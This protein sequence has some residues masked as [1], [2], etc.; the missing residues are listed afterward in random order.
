MTKIEE[1]QAKLATL[2][3][4]AQDHLDKDDNDNA[5]KTMKE[6]KALKT[7][8]DNQIA[9]DELNKT[10]ETP[11][12]KGKG[13]PN[14]N[15]DDKQA[16]NSANFIR[17]CL[18]KIAKKPTT[19]KEDA[20]LL[21]TTALPNGANGEGYILPQDIQ[22]KIN[23][24]IRDFKSFRSVLGHIQ[25]TALTGSFPVENIDDIT[26]LVDFADGTD[27]GFSEDPKFTQIKFALAEKAAFIKLSN[28]LMRLTDND[29]IEY[30]VG[31]FAKKAVITENTMAIAALQN[32]KT[33]KNIADWKALKSSIN[34]DLDPAALYTTKIVTNQ[35]GYDMFDSALDDNG[36]PIMQPDPTNPTV[37]RLFGYEVLVFSNAMLPSTAATTSKPGYAPIFYGAL[38]DGAKFVDLGLTAFKTSEEAGFMSNTTI[39]RLIEF[40]D[41]VQCDSSDACYICG[42]I[43]VEP[44]KS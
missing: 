5:E 1:M 35:D 17:A 2:I 23:E 8:I 26:G 34:K 32:D 43:E 44:K 6:I 14:D 24:R 11:E 31:Y 40:I 38:S 7:K 9:L 13:K 30:I 18:K 33:V 29:L 21:P 20:L 19:E 41:V 37:K 12:P 27:G 3:N 39:A 28:T 25:T 22:T 15:V 10:L 36:R 4:A 42:Q 16:K